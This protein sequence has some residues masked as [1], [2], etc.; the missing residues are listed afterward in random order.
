LLSKRLRSTIRSRKIAINN[1][2]MKDAE[3]RKPISMEAYSEVL[4]S[5]GLAQGGDH[6]RRSLWR[7]WSRGNAGSFSL[8]DT[9][10]DAEAAGDV[11]R[12][13]FQETAAAQSL[14]APPSLRVME[15]DEP[16]S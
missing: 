9:K 13:R 5:P 3:L 16:T 2:K 11:L 15:V 4:G 1:K 12:T 6:L 8:W 14:Q 10:E 7:S